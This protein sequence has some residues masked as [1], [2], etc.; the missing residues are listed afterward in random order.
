MINWKI[1]NKYLPWWD[2]RIF[3]E[4]PLIADIGKLLIIGTTVFGILLWLTASSGLE[5]VKP[6]DL[7]EPLDKQAIQLDLLLDR[8]VSAL[9]GR[10]LMGDLKMQSITLV[11][12]AEPD[13]P[14]TNKAVIYLD[15]T[16]NSLRVKF[17]DGDVVTIGAY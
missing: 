6:F 9:Q 7:K 8:I 3:S 5:V 1:A 14:A 11:E 2:R 10:T 13:T 15:S 4:D 17:D 16:A 12:I